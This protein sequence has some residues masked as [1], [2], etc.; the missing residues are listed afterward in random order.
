MLPLRNP[1]ARPF[2]PHAPASWPAAAP[3]VSVVSRARGHALQSILPPWCITLDREGCVCLLHHLKSS[4]CDLILAASDVALGQG[5]STYLAPS[6]GNWR[7]C[8][9]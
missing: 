3:A 2:C 8:K 7:A 5:P 4:H 1:K 6:S 9:G